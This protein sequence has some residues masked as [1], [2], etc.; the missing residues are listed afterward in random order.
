MPIK[1]MSAL[2]FIGVL[3]MIVSNKTARRQ[4][5]RKTS[6]IMASR[7]EPI[8][9]WNRWW[10]R[11][12]VI[13]KQKRGIPLMDLKGVFQR[14]HNHHAH[15]FVM[16]YFRFRFKRLIMQIPF[17]SFIRITQPSQTLSLILWLN[18]GNKM[19]Y[20]IKRTESRLPCLTLATFLFSPV[21]QPLPSSKLCG[22]PTP[23][24]MICNCLRKTCRFKNL[25][26]R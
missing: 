25:T 3:W 21:L 18:Q 24:G 17:V 22:P 11:K 23:W 19:I 9:D 2:I 6:N 7:Y 12:R 8:E 4:I 15:M 1:N 5:D 10:S 16:V 20:E 14:C 13:K 26:I